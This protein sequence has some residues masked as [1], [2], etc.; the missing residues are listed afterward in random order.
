MTIFKKLDDLRSS[1]LKDIRCPKRETDKVVAHLKELGMPDLEIGEFLLK[2]RTHFRSD[3][4]W[5]KV[6]EFIM[7]YLTLEGMLEAAAAVSMKVL[8]ADLNAGSAYEEYVPMDENET[9]E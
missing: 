1:I 3:D 9:E 2:F 8:I 4:N 5:E 7:N 6:K